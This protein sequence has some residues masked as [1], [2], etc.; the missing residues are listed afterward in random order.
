MYVVQHSSSNTFCCFLHVE[1]LTMG[2]LTLW[3]PRFVNIILVCEHTSS[4]LNYYC[5][6]LGSTALQNALREIP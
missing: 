1:E 4:N 5:L 3:L 2:C 6:L